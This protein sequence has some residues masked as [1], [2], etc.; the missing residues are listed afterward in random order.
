M[1]VLAKITLRSGSMLC[2]RESY[3]QAKLDKIYPSLACRMSKT[4]TC[5]LSDR[6]KLLFIFASPK[7][8]QFGFPSFKKCSNSTHF[9][10]NWV[11]K[12]LLSS[13]S[14]TAWFICGPHDIMRPNKPWMK[15]VI[16]DFVEFELMKKF[17]NP[18]KQVVQGLL[19]V[20][21]WYRTTLK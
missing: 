21:F 20:N 8:F 17:I 7:V 16:P 9:L 3:A 5:F 1:T 6:V 18:K 15:F 12:T 11:Q 2:K 4:W 14:Q 19:F 13:S 10:A